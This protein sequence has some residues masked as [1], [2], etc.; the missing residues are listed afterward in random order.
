MTIATDILL[1]IATEKNG[2]AIGEPWRFSEFSLAAIV[3]LIRVTEDKR[4]YVL[5]S[6]AGEKVKMR[7]TGN[8]NSVEITNN[9]GLPVLV[10][11]GEMVTGATQTRSLVMSQIIMPH[12]KVIADCVCVH[13]TYG[14][15]EGQSVKSGGYSPSTV[16]QVLFTGYTSPHSK[17]HHGHGLGRMVRDFDYKSSLQSNVWQ[18]V[19]SHARYMSS[20]GSNYQARKGRQDSA[21]ILMAAMSKG[22]PTSI[23]DLSEE[24]EE[25]SRPYTTPAEDLQGRTKETQKKYEAILKKVPQVDNQVGIVLID[26][27]GVESLESF[28][29]QDSW[30]ALRKA[31]LGAEAGK[32]ADIS[33]QESA[34]E[35]KSEKAKASIRTLLT[36][37][38]EEAVT[39][40]KQ[41]TSTFL[42]DSSKVWGEVVT[43]YGKSIHCA[44]LRKA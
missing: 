24:L 40:E 4:L 9:H 2:Y 43:L 33:D 42:L 25:L 36:A 34:F 3:P 20:L 15:R 14:I 13:S 44:I 7:D 26:L 8:I 28:E 38:Y 27:S 31:L 18:G 5:L 11:A 30:D 39:V 37:K 41:D 23:P 17:P 22:D 16:R 32:I 12:E 1:D 29:H 10:K 19:K 21:E 35:F 6:E